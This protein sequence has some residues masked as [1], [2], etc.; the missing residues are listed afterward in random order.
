M[1]VR[2]CL[3]VIDRK[4]LSFEGVL[5]T[6]TARS[7]KELLRS[8]GFTQVDCFWHWMNFAGWVAVRES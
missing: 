1:L 8:V 7:N 3:G 2:V 4:R 6:V 5:V